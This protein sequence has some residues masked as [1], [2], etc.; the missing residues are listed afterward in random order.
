MGASTDWSPDR[1]TAPRI[2][3][4]TWRRQGKVWGEFV[5]DMVGVEVQYVQAVQNAGGLALL[6]PH[7]PGAEP[8]DLLAA[9]DGLMV[10]GGEDIAAEVSGV[11]P[12]DVGTN[13]SADRDRW[14]ISLID[15]AVELRVP[16]LAICRG[17]QLLNVARG[18]TL[19]GDIAGSSD[20][21]PAVPSS[22]LQ[23]A[24][25]HRHETRFADGSL[26]AAAYGVPAKPTNS[27]HHQAVDRV[28][29]GLVVTARA[30]DG[31]VEGLELPGARWCVGVEWHPELVPDD[32]AEAGLF[33]AFVEHCE[34][35]A[36]E[37]A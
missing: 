8:R 31:V 29:D 7:A 35:V 11:D 32:P 17:M 37:A 4:T 1:S 9:V 27:L 19:L 13:A 23:A 16:V 21:H 25:T 3:L 30:A 6:A 28:G 10:I 15:A 33:R 20:D 36:R 18:G 34:T 5:R 24:L 12:G 26:L 14:E 2:L 22:D